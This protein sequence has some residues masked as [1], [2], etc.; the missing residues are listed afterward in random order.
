MPRDAGQVV[1][2]V[3][4][5]LTRPHREDDLEPF[6][7]ESPERVVMA[8]AALPAPIVVGARPFAVPEGEEG[9]LV[10]GG[11]QVP[12][13]GKPEGD[14]VPLPHKCQSSGSLAGSEI[15]GL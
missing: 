3:V 6:G 2:F 11:A 14:E 1:L 10:D 4:G 5:H 13:A 7:P 8:V 12:V 9:E 15:S